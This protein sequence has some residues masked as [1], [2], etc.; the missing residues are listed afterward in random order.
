MTSSKPVSNAVEYE[1]LQF[2]LNLN[3]PSA[4]GK[5]LTQ[6]PGVQNASQLRTSIVSSNGTKASYQLKETIFLQ[7]VKE[8]DEEEKANKLRW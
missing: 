1:G 4:V 8:I 2:P 3:T 7:R 6:N 5:V